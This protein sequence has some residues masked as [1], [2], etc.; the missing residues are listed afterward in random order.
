MKAREKNMTM[1]TQ[2]C[3]CVFVAA[4]LPMNT[5]GCEVHTKQSYACDECKCL[6]YKPKKAPV[7]DGKKGFHWAL[8]TCGHAAQSHN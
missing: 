5:T 8:C 7:P 6:S 4:G 3:T 1:K 2:V